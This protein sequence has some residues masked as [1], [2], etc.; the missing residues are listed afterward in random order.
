[1][2][3]NQKSITGGGGRGNKNS[4]QTGH[5]TTKIAA[6]TNT[7]NTILENNPKTLTTIKNDIHP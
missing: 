2:A 1:M 3:L 4:T 6:A 5:T 7:T